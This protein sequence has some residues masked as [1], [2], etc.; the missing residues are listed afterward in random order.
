MERELELNKGD[1][2]KW[3]HDDGLRRGVVM[4]DTDKAVLIFVSSGDEG[5]GFLHRKHWL[6]RSRIRRKTGEPAR[7]PMPR[8]CAGPTRAP[9]TTPSSDARGWIASGIS[10][11]RRTG[12]CNGNASRR[13]R[14]LLSLRVHNPWIAINEK[15]TRSGSLS[16]QSRSYCA[17][18]FWA[19]QACLHSC[20]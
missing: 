14:K 9:T 5:D 20:L 7:C 4:T 18:A 2:V 17:D 8:P 19:F 12:R 11:P 3:E 6:P 13:L 15:G 16:L 1:E 10:R